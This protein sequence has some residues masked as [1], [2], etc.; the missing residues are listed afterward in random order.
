MQT[1]NDIRAAKM[2][3]TTKL[4]LLWMLDRPAH[5]LRR[6]EIGAA[7][8]L[9]AAEAERGI[10]AGMTRAPIVFSATGPSGE[11]LESR[12]AF[13]PR[14]SPI[15]AAWKIKTAPLKEDAA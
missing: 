12:F 11:R 15:R 8:G 13:I 5:L 10:R 7:L 2:D 6:E 4:I 1:A 3:P 14:A 9:S